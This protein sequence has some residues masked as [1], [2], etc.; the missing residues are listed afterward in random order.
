[1]DYKTLYAKTPPTRLFFK[2]ALPGSVGMLASSV[3]QLI[4]GMLVGQILGSTA[5]AALNLAMPFVIINFALADLIGVGSS[6]AISIWLGEKNEK[7][8]GNLFTCACLMILGAAFFIG[9]LLFAGAPLFMR[10][11]GAEG[12]LAAQAV[13]YLRVYALFSPLT[14]IL[15]AVDNYLRICGKIRTSMVLNIFMA[16]MCALLE[17]IFL[18]VFRFGVWGAA[19]GTCTSMSICTVIA[20]V[21]FFR[22]KL[23]LKFCRP[24][25]SL[26]SVRRTLSCGCPVFLNNVAGRAASILMNTIL[27]QVGGPAAV[28]TYGILMYID[29]FIQPLLYGMCDSLQPAV[30]FNWGAGDYGRVTAIEKRCFAASAILSLVFSAVIFFFPEQA[31]GLFTQGSDPEVLSMAVPAVT[32]FSATYVTRWFSF[33]S[34]SFMSAI[35]KPLLASIISITTVLIFPVLLILIF[36]PLGLTGLWL[37]LPGTALLSA[38][39][40]AAILLKIR[41]QLRGTDK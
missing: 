20:F 6:V 13:Q 37:N 26:R 15:F 9:A 25:F 3:Y 2:A 27:L 24:R 30:G 11:M 4:D 33:A 10:L 31:A 35:E 34:Q 28:S 23:A 41:G 19:L 36:W 22:G 7:E 40:S 21:P 8:A 39:L 5:F 18:Y 1:M 29:G 14:T 17:F 16:A 32:I 38:A 12:E